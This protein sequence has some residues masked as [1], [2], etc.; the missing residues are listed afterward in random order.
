MST[1]KH[2]ASILPVVAGIVL[3]APAW[4]AQNQASL[5]GTIVLPPGTAKGAKVSI[6]SGKTAM[7]QRISSDGA[8][9]FSSLAPGQY[10]VT[11]TAAKKK[12]VI[13]TILIEPGANEVILYFPPEIDDELRKAKSEEA[14]NEG[15]TLLQAGSYQAAISKLKEALTWDTARAATW[16]ALALAYLGAKEYAMAEFAGMMA[17]RLEPN[18]ASYRNNLGGTYFRMQMYEE[19]V[20]QYR[21]AAQLNPGGVGMYMANAGAALQA[22]GD[23]AAATQAYKDACESGHAPPEAWYFLG[24]LLAKGGDKEGAIS[25]LKRY[26]DEL[27]TGAYAENAKKALRALGVTIQ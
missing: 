19:A 21:L 2:Y 20:A 5:E 27:P 9:A 24:T 17:V 18:E 14:F 13:S 12:L 4:T 3:S 8:F 11:I 15:S 10:S 1:T 23:F 22:A 7:E 16:G 25:A 26:L 6:L